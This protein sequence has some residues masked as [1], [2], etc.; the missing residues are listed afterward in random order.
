[1]NG[2]R[3]AKDGPVFMSPIGSNVVIGDGTLISEEFYG[4]NGRRCLFLNF[5]GGC[6]S[7]AYTIE[8]CTREDFAFSLATYPQQIPSIRLKT[9]DFCMREWEVLSVDSHFLCMY[10]ASK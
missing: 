2:H 10:G 7:R 8:V 3:W 5:L 6:Q 9:K 1:M 4:W